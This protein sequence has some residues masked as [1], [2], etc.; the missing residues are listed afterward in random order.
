MQFKESYQLNLFCSQGKEEALVNAPSNHD[1]NAAAT[2][3]HFEGFSR[4]QKLVYQRGNKQEENQQQQCQT[5][6]DCYNG[7]R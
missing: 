4:S 1:E 3:V 5:K 6:N 7:T 2:S